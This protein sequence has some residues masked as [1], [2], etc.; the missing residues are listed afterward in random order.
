MRNTAIAI[1][2]VVAVVLG[3][4]LGSL[5][6]TAGTESQQTD[7]YDL[8]RVGDYRPPF[9][10]GTTTGAID[11]I[12]NYS[13]KV[14]LVNF[15]ATWCTPC[16]EEIPMLQALQLQYGSQ[17]FQVIG[18]AMDD[19]ARVRMFVAELGIDYPNMVGAGDV[20]MTGLAY[21]NS[22]GSLPYSVLVDREGIIR[23]RL[24]GEIDRETFSARLEQLL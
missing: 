24:H 13:G 17:G 6:D 1:F 21:G 23:W 8:V 20:M 10:H 19:V 12:D 2:A 7:K 22:S 16:R 15:W 3:F 18:I 4:Y 9:S 11:N 5:W 14:V